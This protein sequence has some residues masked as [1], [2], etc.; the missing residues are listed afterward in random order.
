MPDQPTESDLNQYSIS[1]VRV[2]EIV[3]IHRRLY[4]VES[5][6]QDEGWS[7]H[8]LPVITITLRPAYIG[9]VP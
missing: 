9:A 1:D 3:E 4:I 7:R 8:L 6:R 5:V 2:G